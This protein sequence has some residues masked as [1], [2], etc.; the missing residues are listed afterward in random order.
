VPDE[1]IYDTDTRDVVFC[2]RLAE[3]RRLNQLRVDALRD[4]AQIQADVERL[5]ERLDTLWYAMTD[6]E[7]AELDRG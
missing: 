4:I 6:A 5:L 3:Y 1:T 2:D 7:R